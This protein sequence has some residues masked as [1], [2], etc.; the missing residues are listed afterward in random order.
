MPSRPLEILDRA[1][2]NLRWLEESLPSLFT[3]TLRHDEEAI[4][5]LAAGLGRLRTDRQLVVADRS[6]ELILARLDIPGS[7]FETLR[8]LED[9]DISRA[10][11]PTRAASCP[12][13]TERSRS[14]GTSSSASP[15]P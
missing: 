4:A 7:I 1:P 14:S 11:D 9:R 10:R 13:A 15:M 5:A 6:H 8:G 12:A 3:G 2:E